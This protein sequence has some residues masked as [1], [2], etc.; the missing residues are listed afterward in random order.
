MANE[1]LC[2]WQH[3]D[4]EEKEFKKFDEDE[5]RKVRKLSIAKCRLNVCHRVFAMLGDAHTILSFS[6]LHHY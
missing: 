5:L 2:H 1:R 4:D 6:L 3:E